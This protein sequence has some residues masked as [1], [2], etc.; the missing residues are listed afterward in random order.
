MR[1]KKDV[2]F[3]KMLHCFGLRASGFEAIPHPSCYLTSNVDKSYHGQAIAPFSVQ[4]LQFFSY[5]GSVPVSNQPF[6]PIDMENIA[7]T[8]HLG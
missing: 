7:T 8:W 6:S 2:L 3:L 5:T 4:L 1:L